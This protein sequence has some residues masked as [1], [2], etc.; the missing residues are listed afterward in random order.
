MIGIFNFRDESGN[1]VHYRD[2]LEWTA[3]NSLLPDSSFWA[4]RATY[5]TLCVV[6]VSGYQQG[7]AAGKIARRILV[8][9]ESPSDIPMT[10]TAKGQPLVS[11][12]RAKE[13][14]I[15]IPSKTLLSSEVITEYGWDN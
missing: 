5:G 4:D 8:D 14:G 12:A 2:V 6:S 7:L 10:R 1:N 3:R 11:L 13:L 15:A 9:G